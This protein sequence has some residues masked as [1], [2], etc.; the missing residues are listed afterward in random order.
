MTYGCVKP[1]LPFMPV[2]RSLCLSCVAMGAAD[3]FLQSTL[4]GFIKPRGSSA[5]LIERISAI[6]TGDL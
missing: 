5:C 2:F 3:I 1:N 6:S 4:P